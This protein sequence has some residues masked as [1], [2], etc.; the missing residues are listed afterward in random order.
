MT[1]V[2]FPEILDAV[3][4]VKGDCSEVTLR[5][6]LRDFDIQPAG[7]VRQRPLR[8]PS[9]TAQRVL[10][11]LGLAEAPA[12]APTIRRPGRIVTMSELR[13]IRTKA[14]KE[15]ARRVK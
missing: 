2:T 8:Y 9:D 11:Y 1:T 10:S 13:A 7:V 15:K 12:G 14:N 5:R 4:R 6:Y 3:R